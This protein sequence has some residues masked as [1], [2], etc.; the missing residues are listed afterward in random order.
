MFLKNLIKNLP[1][2]KK[3]IQ[4]QGLATNSKN[5]KKNFI[6]FAI[7]GHKINGERYIDEAISRGAIAII[8]SNKCKYTN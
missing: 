3:N 6:F 4:V 1:Q 7:R 5:V 2:N 8:C